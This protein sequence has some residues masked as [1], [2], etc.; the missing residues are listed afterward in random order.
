LIGTAGQSC[1]AGKELGAIADHSKT[2][3]LHCGKGDQPQTGI[4]RS[5]DSENLEL[6]LF[7]PGKAVAAVI[8][9]HAVLHARLKI[10]EVDQVEQVKGQTSTV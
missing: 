3:M 8:Y 7:T 4:H 2:I 5:K 6:L 1:F 10:K 9:A